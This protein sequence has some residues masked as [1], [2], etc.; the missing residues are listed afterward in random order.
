ME[1]GEFRILGPFYA[2]MFVAVATMAIFPFM[3]VY[4]LDL[5]FSLSQYF[6]LFGVWTAGTVFFEVPTGAVADA[7]SRKWSVIIGL[8]M[9]GVTAIGM[10]LTE[11][12]PL[13][14]LL[15]A[16]NGIGFTFFSGAEDAWAI[17]NLIH[18]G[19]ED[20]VEQFYSKNQAIMYLG[21]FLGPLAA[22]V[23]V[24]AWGIRPL[25]FVWGGG[26]LLSAVA[27]TAIR[28]HYTPT[29]DSNVTPMKLTL[30]QT[31]ETLRLLVKDRNLGLAFLATGFLALLF[32]D[33]GFWQPLLIDLELPVAGIGYLSAAAAAVGVAMSL[34]IPRLNRYDFRI[35]MVLGIITKMAILFI[36]PLLFGPRF[37][38]ASAM[39]MAVEASSTFEGP[40]LTPYIQQRL[41]SHLRATAMSVKSMVAKLI[42]GAGG[43]AFAAVAD[44]TTL[45][46]VF[47]IIAVFGI[48]AIV[49]LL[50]ID[51]KPPQS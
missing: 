49:T 21:M 35:V 42:M 4:F 20:L 48:G 9:A 37:L 24:G 36:L 22:G 12:Y 16:I 45:R 23:M 40:L 38:L 7:F 32:L 11:S 27:L 44:N 5:G 2:Y 47:P 50:R 8:V 39:Y 17:D 26:Y 18:Y 46:T 31:T 15:F 33:T 43:I 14:L 3:V 28:E 10:G 29:R 1:T 6:V 34:L 25:W 13:L 30:R 19:R 51:R 41:P